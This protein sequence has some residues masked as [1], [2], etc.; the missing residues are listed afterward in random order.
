MTEFFD[1]RSD[2]LRNW[3]K[4]FMPNYQV[5]LQSELLDGVT[6]GVKYMSV[7]MNPLILLPWLKEN[8]AAK[9]VRFIRAEVRSIDEARSL[10]KAKIVVNASGVGAKTLAGDNAVTPVRGQTMFVKSEFDELV[11][12]EGSE[13]T[14]II[15][16]AR[17]GG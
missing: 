17:S 15:P 11:M 16:R 8:L 4:T 3:Y 10:T 9:G 2:D 7:A 6:F 1:D 12:R 13:Y 5:I 14:Y